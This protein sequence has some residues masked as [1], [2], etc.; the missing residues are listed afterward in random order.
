MS[1][2]SNDVC[3]IYHILASRI[4]PVISHTMIT[5]ERARYLCAMLIE[6]PID[7]SFVVTTTMMYVRHLDKGFALP[8]GALI[9]RIM[10]H[11][12]VDMTG[13]REIQLAKGAMGV[14]FLNA[15]QAH[16]REVEKEPRA[17]RPRRPAKVGRVP[18]RIEERLDRLE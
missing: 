10:E 18:T 12:R 13:L 2:F 1:D 6:A 15:S 3:C 17:Q 4:L 7:Y 14:R 5:I 8:Y 11:A 16:L 9:T